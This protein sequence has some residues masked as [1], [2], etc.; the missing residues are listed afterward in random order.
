MSPD[1][2]PIADE[3]RRRRAVWRSV[4]RAPRREA[5]EEE[6]IDPLPRDENWIADLGSDVG[7]DGLAGPNR[8]GPT[9]LAWMAVEEGL[10]EQRALI[11][12]L[13]A[14]LDALERSVADGPGRRGAATLFGPRLVPF[15]RSASGFLRWLLTRNVR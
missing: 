14:R 1:A 11:A 7:D 15:A 10:H 13:T 12:A 5:T 8:A 2:P 4:A 9:A 3:P 6:F